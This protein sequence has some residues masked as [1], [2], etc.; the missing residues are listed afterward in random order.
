MVDPTYDVPGPS[1][2]DMRRSDFDT[3]EPLTLF[4]VADVATATLPAKPDRY[5]T[6]D[7]FSAGGE[8]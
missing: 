1:W 8:S 5:G 4:D 7:L 3:D 6:P 2:L